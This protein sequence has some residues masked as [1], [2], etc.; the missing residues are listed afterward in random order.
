MVRDVISVVAEFMVSR[1][2]VVRGVISVVAEFMVSRP[3]CCDI[4]YEDTGKRRGIAERDAF[5]SC[6]WP[7]FTSS[8]TSSY[9]ES[10]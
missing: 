9:R 2:A 4:I 6:T 3:E 7:G 1:P 10:Q 8:Y 5:G